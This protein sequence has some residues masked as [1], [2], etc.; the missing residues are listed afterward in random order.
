M[1][2]AA[3]FVESLILASSNHYHTLTNDFRVTAGTLAAVYT[4]ALSTVMLLSLALHAQI[5][6]TTRKKQTT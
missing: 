3:S 4:T 2:L 5:E 1:G 6:S